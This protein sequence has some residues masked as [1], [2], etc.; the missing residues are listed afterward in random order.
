[1]TRLHHPVTIPGL[2][3]EPAAPGTVLVLDSLGGVQLAGYGGCPGDPADPPHR[4]VTIEDLVYKEP[5]P[6]GPTSGGLVTINDPTP[7]FLTIQAGAG[8]IV[9]S[10]DDPYNVTVDEVVWLEQSADATL[11]GAPQAY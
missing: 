6:T 8:V 1:M 3:L 2:L 5:W 7:N 9:N 11:P 10:Y 4:P